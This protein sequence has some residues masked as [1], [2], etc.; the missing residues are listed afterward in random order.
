M[1]ILL[2]SA[3]VKSSLLVT[4]FAVLLPLSQVVQAT[5][6]HVSGLQRRNWPS[7]TD[8]RLAV[9]YQTDESGLATGWKLPRSLLRQTDARIRSVDNSWVP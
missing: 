1:L 2:P 4:S 3:M 9:R 5:F 6:D 7:S 8:S